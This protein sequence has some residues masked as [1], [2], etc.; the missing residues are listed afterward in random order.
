MG[1]NRRAKKAKGGTQ[2][3]DQS[4]W[5]WCPTVSI[6]NLPLLELEPISN[7]ID[8]IQGRHI[9]ALKFIYITCNVPVLPVSSRSN[10]FELC[11][12]LHVMINLY[13]LATLFVSGPRTRCLHHWRRIHPRS[14]IPGRIGVVRSK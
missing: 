7:F 12:F 6:M 14:L 1:E 2:V 8:N 4:E 5:H 13:S 11:K 3:L 9:L 10:K